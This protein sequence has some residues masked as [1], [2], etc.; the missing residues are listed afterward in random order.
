MSVLMSSKERN[1]II[2]LNVLRGIE[3]LIYFENCILRRTKP[4]VER[5]GGSMFSAPEGQKGGSFFVSQKLFFGPYEPQELQE[6]GASVEEVLNNLRKRT[7][8]LIAPTVGE[9][10]WAHRI[11][12]LVHYHSPDGRCFVLDWREGERQFD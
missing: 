10:H 7:G 1:R 12:T 9:I 6:S 8:E 4:S 11:E 3:F 5:Q 2:F